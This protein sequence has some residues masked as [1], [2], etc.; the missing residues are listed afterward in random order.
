MAPPP[1]EQT[2]KIA[3][4]TYALS[5]FGMKVYWALVY[6][7]L[8]FDL[9][10]VSPRGQAEIAFTGQ[11]VVPVL[12]VDEDWRLD[13]GPIC[14]WLDDMF[15]DRPVA[16][17]NEEARAAI[18]A[19]DEWVTRNIIG[20]GF[21][22]AVDPATRFAA[23]WDGRKLAQVMRKTSG[24]IPWSAQF[25]WSRLIR[26]AKFIQDG[27]AMTDQSKSFSQLEQ[28]TI[29]AFDTKLESTGFLAGTEAPS[30]ADL[31]A[32]AQLACATDLKF[33]RGLNASSSPEIADWFARVANTLPRY[34]HPEL[35]TGRKP[36]HTT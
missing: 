32:F 12:K 17:E 34:D 25:V 21:R 29:T 31:S 2:R 36:A 8:D 13:S 9:H 24:G 30:Y 10:Y 16:G 6:K 4:Y 7:G 22:K 19:A 15:P 26:Q 35:I 23:F 11:H 1:A 33:M 3:L 28:D 18:L 5:P 20:L 27:A 14:Q